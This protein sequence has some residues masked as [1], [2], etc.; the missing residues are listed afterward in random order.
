MTEDAL[1]RALIE[2]ATFGELR[3]RLVHSGDH[4]G[5]MQ[6]DRRLQSLLR[7]MRREGRVE[8]HRY[9]DRIWTRSE[10]RTV[11]LREAH[12]VAG[13]EGVRFC[14]SELREHR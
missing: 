11:S 2:P 12:Q 5:N 14:T 9:R 4:R 6:D 8:L 7:A 13:S 1:L 3:A 10:W